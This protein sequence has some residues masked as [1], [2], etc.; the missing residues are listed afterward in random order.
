MGCQFFCYLCC[1]CKNVNGTEFGSTAMCCFLAVWYKPNKQK[2]TQSQRYNPR[3]SFFSS[4]LPVWWKLNIW[5]DNHLT[6]HVTTIAKECTF[7]RIEWIYQSFCIQNPFKYLVELTF[8]WWLLCAGFFFGSCT[9]C[10]SVVHTHT[11]ITIFHFFFSLSVDSWQSASSVMKNGIIFV[12]DSF[13]RITTNWQPPLFIHKHIWI[14]F[15]WTN[16]CP[17]LIHVLSIIFYSSLLHTCSHRSLE[18][19]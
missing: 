4:A 17:F 6:F 2:K 19:R 3:E 12:C 7:K 5:C 8:L 10:I 13:F 18:R 11:S 1:C 16:K 15:M 9:F 14:E